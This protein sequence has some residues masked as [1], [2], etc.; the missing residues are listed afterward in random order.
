MILATMVPGP[1]SSG[2]TYSRIGLEQKYGRH[3]SFSG[4]LEGG[5][6]EVGILVNAKYSSE[7]L[8]LH[9]HAHSKSSAAER[10]GDWLLYFQRSHSCG[11]KK[12]H[13]AVIEMIFISHGL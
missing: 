4:A 3:S 9:Q 10:T 13:H 12:K 7:L 1:S 2:I 6:W 5:V 11:C 8:K